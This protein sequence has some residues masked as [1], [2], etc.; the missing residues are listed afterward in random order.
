MG[1]N[2]MNAVDVPVMVIFWPEITLTNVVWENVLLSWGV[3]LSDCKSG[4]P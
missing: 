1:L 2:Q 4:M 3:H